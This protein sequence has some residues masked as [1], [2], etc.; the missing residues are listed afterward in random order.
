MIRS[1][2]AS[3]SSGASSTSGGI[4][5]RS[6][7][8][9]A[10]GNSIGEVAYGLATPSGGAWCQLPGAANLNDIAHPSYRDRR[11]DHQ[12]QLKC[13]RAGAIGA[14]E[15]E[16]P[17]VG[18]EIDDGEARWLVERCTQA[19]NQ[20]PGYWH[21]CMELLGYP[22][23][24]AYTVGGPG[25]QS[26]FV[27]D[28]A[29]RALKKCDPGILFISDLFANDVSQLLGDMD[30]YRAA[31]GRVSEF[32]DE[33]IRDGRYLIIQG[34]CPGPFGTEALRNGAGY[35]HGQI[36]EWAQA[37]ASSCLLWVAPTEEVASLVVGQHWNP[38]DVTTYQAVNSIFNKITDGIHP[39]NVAHWRFAKSL[40]PEIAKLG[41]PSQQ[42]QDY[43]DR[44]RW[45][46]PRNL[47]TA[48]TLN[49][50][51]TGQAPNGWMVGR[52]G[53][54]TAVSALELRED[55]VGGYWW[56]LAASSAN[57]GKIWA[58]REQ[59]LA[60]LGFSVGDE[61]EFLAELVNADMSPLAFGA[62]VEI[63]F[64]NASEYPAF[65]S[66][67]FTNG[68]PFGQAMGTDNLVQIAKPIPFALKVPVGATNIAV[69]LSIEGSGAWSGNIKLGRININNRSL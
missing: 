42:F 68:Q 45:D 35:F 50:G 60:A 62:R 29:R 27:I 40:A 43:G 46:N 9:L 41:F 16:W 58:F 28:H 61:I 4:R 69:T 36:V 10:I 66:L 11:K 1:T 63:A 65:A 38:D 22:L 20:N 54:A 17:D 39:Q 64:W 5:P 8:T 14:T 3:R 37:N 53:V 33:Q 7:L 15:P 26:D 57:G 55:G 31:W 30:L 21:I 51:V 56:S 49:A 19:M 47:G 52:D 67:N 13:V 12:I 6:A 23:E 2:N 48:G 59:S 24:L 34:V 18:Q 32:L 44:Q 25:R